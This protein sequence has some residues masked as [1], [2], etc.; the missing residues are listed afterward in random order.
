M[1]SKVQSC[2]IC[3]QYHRPQP[4]DEMGCW[5]EP[6]KPGEVIGFDFMG[7][8]FSKGNRKKCWV[9]VIIDW[10]SR[11]GEAWMVKGIGAREV[12][13]GLNRWERQHGRL[14]VVCSDTVQANRSKAIQEWGR[15][16]D[17]KLEV[18]P[19]FHHASLGLVERFNQTL[20]HQI[21]KM[22]LEEGKD[23]KGIVRCAVQVY[24]ETPLSR[25]LGSPMRLWGAGRAVWNQLIEHSHSQ[26]EKANCRVKGRR[27]GQKLVLGQ[28]VWLW[29]T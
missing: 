24:N 19:P 25:R 1:R 12:G 8:F 22:W 21:R 9:L 2:K 4:S 11:L 7:P 14:R 28:R 16:R 20:L 18:S 6:D 5:H 27:W 3:Q 17:V 29:D 23:F 13:E 10:L 26:R 15:M